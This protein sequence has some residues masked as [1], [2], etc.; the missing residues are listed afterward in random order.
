MAIR[1]HGPG[2]LPEVH[3]KLFKGLVTTKPSG[4]GTGLIM[5]HH[6]MKEHQGEIDIKGRSGLGTT[7]RLIFA[8]RW[9]EKAS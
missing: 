7:V 6:I 3:E 5:V 9:K 1:D 2:I 4:T 8:E